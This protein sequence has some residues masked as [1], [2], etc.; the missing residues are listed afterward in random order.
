[1]RGA[2][3]A[4]MIAG[5]TA[6]VA[7]VLPPTAIAGADEP[8]ARVVAPQ[9]LSAPWAAAVADLRRQI[10]QL[11]PSDCQ[12]MTLS[13]EPQEG[14]MRIVAVAGDGRR[15]ERV[16]KHSES[17]VA[18]SLGLLMAIPGERLAES[19]A[20]PP[21]A[22]TPPRPP[23]PIPSEP[24]VASPVARATTAPEPRT[25]GLLAGFSGGIRL[26]APTSLSVLDVEAR[27]DIVFD[28]WLMLVTLRSALVSCL[29]QQGVD[30]DVYNDVSAGF[31]VGRRFR[32]SGPTI[33]VAF[34]P[35]L[36]VMHMEYDAAPAGEGQTLED[37][38][39]VLRFDASARLAMPV[40]RHWALTVTLDGG[41]A[42][43][44]LTNP[45]RLDLPAGTATGA[46]PPPPFPAWSGGVRLGALGALL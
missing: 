15:A 27:A 36:A 45:A 29:G 23:V 7:F 28:R 8:C 10:A 22:A 12:T 32:T 38:E 5:S 34:E 17:L 37:T 31:G 20:A 4:R 44:M 14:G 35:S 9:D 33:D 13:L 30:C 2:E 39:V 25:I 46:A 1:V 16:A 21:P 43:S 26:T 24:P 11:P 6:G 3:L 19:D 18:M 42:P 41:L 40:D